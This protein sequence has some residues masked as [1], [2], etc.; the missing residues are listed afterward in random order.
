M[1]RRPR[2]FVPDLRA[3]VQALPEGEA[4]HVRRVLR[5]KDGDSVELFDGRGSV[6]AGTLVAGGVEAA[7]IEAVAPPPSLTVL[8]ATPKGERAD[9][10]VEK[11]AELGVTAWVPL[12]TSR[13]VV[14][15]GAGK[16]DKYRRRAVEAA[17]QAGTAFV[18]RVEEPVAVTDV[19][20]GGGVVLS[21]SAGA[22]PLLGAGPVGRV[23]V[24]PEGGWTEDEEA[25]F[26][27]AGIGAATLGAT[28]LRVE[29]AAVVASGMLRACP[30]PRTPAT[31]RT[32][33][34]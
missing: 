8:A 32:G 24:G 31:A 19:L 27:A 14:T 2:L 15:P 21:L 13:S 17:K 12:V 20:D 7:A 5:L 3:G 4:K 10:M 26:A 6:A 1:S 29:T 18:L 11:L 33:R 28:A 25:A 34:G 22:G 23:F 9:W 30:A 16:L